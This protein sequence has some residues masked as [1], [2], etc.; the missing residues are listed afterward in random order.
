MLSKQAL[1]RFSAKEREA[2]YQKWGVG[3]KTKN[4]RLQLC[5]QIWT[6]TKDMN[7]VKDSAALVAKLVGFALSSQTPKEMFG[8]SFSTRSTNRRSSFNLR[9][10]MSALT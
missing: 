8:L 6:D 4:R 7:H 2:L 1:R 9:H 5:H 3:L 10:S